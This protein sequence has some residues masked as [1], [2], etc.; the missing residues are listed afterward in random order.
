MKAISYNG[1]R[2]ED[3]TQILQIFTEV[4]EGL[5][6]FLRF[7]TMAIRTVVEEFFGDFLMTSVS[8]KWGECRRNLSFLG[9]FRRHFSGFLV[10]EGEFVFAA[11]AL[12]GAAFS[13]GVGECGIK[14]CC[15]RISA[16]F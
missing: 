6:D 7:F 9:R 12:D 1:I 11:E 16:D 3:L 14:P 2:A 15:G 10:E 13:A 5:D 8:E 4:D